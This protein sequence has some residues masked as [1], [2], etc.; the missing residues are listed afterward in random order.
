M[1]SKVIKHDRL[2]IRVTKEE[3]DEIFKLKSEWGVGLLDLV[4]K[5]IETTKKENCM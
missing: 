1:D 4:R 3:K 2:F 5:G